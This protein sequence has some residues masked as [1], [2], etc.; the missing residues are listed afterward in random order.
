MSY[1]TWSFFCLAVNAFAEPI[2]RA[3]PEL[4]ALQK[5]AEQR[6]G[7]YDKALGG[8]LLIALGKVP[9]ASDL[10]TDVEV[11][12]LTSDA[13]ILRSR[14]TSDRVLIV[15]AGRTIRAVGYAFFELLQLL[16]FAF[17]HPLKPV[18]PDVLRLQHPL[19]VHESPRWEFR[20][21]HYHT[22]HPLE[23]TNLLNGYDADGQTENR[24]RWALALNAWEDYLDWLLAQKQNYVEWMLLADRRGRDESQAMTSFEVSDERRLRLQILVE[25]AHA[26]G[27]EVGA[28]VPLSLKQQ[29]ALNL[30]PNPRQN[31]EEQVRGRVRWLRSCGF[32]HLGTELG[33]TEFTRGLRATEM[34]R[35]L[36][37]TQDELGSQKLLVKNHCSTNQHADGFRDP[38]P[39]KNKKTLNFNYLNYFANPQIVSMPHT[40]Q[41]YSLLDPAPTYGNTNF[42]D[43]R[44]W[45]SFLLQQGR[46]VVFY[47]E[48]AY[49]VNFDI[50]VPLF[51]APIYSLDRVEDADTL[52]AI[53]GSVPLMGQLNFESGWQWG[54]WLANSVQ[55]LVAWRPLTLM[56][57]FQHLLRF[58]GPSSRK[59]A[60]LLTD[61]AT[62][63][64]RLLIRGI[65]QGGVQTIP[66]PG[67]GPGS[68]TGIAYLQG[69]EGLS[70]FASVVAR[71]LGEGAPQPDRLHFMELWHETPPTGRLLRAVA[72]GSAAIKDVLMGQLHLQRQQWFQEHLRP[73]L[74]ETNSTF[75]ALAKRFEEFQFQLGH[76]EVEDL[77]VSARMLSLRSAQVLALYEYAAMCIPKKTSGTDA[78]CASRLAVAR[79]ALQTAEALAKERSHQMGLESLGPGAKRLIL[80]WG[81]PIPTAYS[82]GYLWAAHTLFYWHRDQDMV[83]QQIANLCFR[84]INDP[85]ELGLTGGGGPW[86]HWVQSAARSFLSN[87]L[88]HSKLSECLGPP[89]E[90]KPGNSEAIV[91]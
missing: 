32:D 17:L 78:W 11:D 88:W 90:P 36:N 31:H 53:P 56:E 62:E 21:S 24:E 42:S 73:L 50:S 81:E 84:S 63:Q 47:P 89:V 15:C 39:G 70:D 64:R 51:L 45:T 33:S 28:D 87:R 52:D 4:W 58:L 61:Y 26:R 14:N 77:V 44:N 34:I 82:Y 13:F 43:L 91:M 7:H 67:T 57:A 66:A 38:R 72:E 16:G 3:P 40:V 86:A 80:E 8:N 59:L 75:A 69:S 35:L 37:I 55:A 48:T 29:H 71:S 25:A 27:L 6:L 30:L 76:P 19:D 74:I 65:R 68:A 9:E 79:S 46:P 83:E 10:V 60:E 5:S 1:V 85:V 23:L 49:W 54:Y 2:I 22:Q 41:A 20:G 18:Y 12:S